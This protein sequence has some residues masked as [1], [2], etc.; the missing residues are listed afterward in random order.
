MIRGNRKRGEGFGIRILGFL[1]SNFIAKLLS[2][3][4]ESLIFQGL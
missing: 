1:A 2:K 3:S 4:L